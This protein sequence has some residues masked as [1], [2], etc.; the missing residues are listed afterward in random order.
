MTRLK[1][2]PSKM[3]VLMSLFIT[4]VHANEDQALIKDT[5]FVSGQVF[6]KGFF[7]YDD[8]VQKTEEEITEATPPVASSPQPVQEEKIELNSKWLKDNMPRLL[9]QA[10]DNP[11]PANLS[12]F[13]TAQRLML[14]IGTRFSDKSKDYFLKNPMMSEK[15]RQPV[16]K[17]ALD[18]HRT[19]VEKNQQTVMKDIFTKSGLFFFFQSTCE[20]CHEESQ[21]LQFMQNYYSVDILPVSM[22]GRPLQNGLFQD[23][24]I[25]NAQIID[26]FKIREVPTIFLVS[27]DG[28]SA[29][30]ISEGMITAEELKNTIILAAKGMNLIDDALFQSTLDIKRQYTIGEDGVITVNKSEMDSDP[31]LLQRIMDQKLEGYDMP[32]ADPVNYLN[33]GGSLGGSYAH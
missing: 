1:L 20:F 4:G 14:D 26:Q 32:T 16:E 30:R 11:T 22:D 13:Y 17:V 2:M 27:K 33:V 19:V 24:S 7:W 28:S 23:F 5:P 9:T 25:P 29:Q 12:R 18:A 15:R 10:M 3:L 8:P 21:I 31:F 6:K